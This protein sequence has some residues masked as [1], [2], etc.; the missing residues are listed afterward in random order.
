MVAVTMP[1]GTV[2]DDEESKE[3]D[4]DERPRHEDQDGVWYG[5]ASMNDDV[6]EE[7]R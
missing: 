7:L 6:F 4:D 3:M 1:T 5:R 2:D